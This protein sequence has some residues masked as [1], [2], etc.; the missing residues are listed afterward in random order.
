MVIIV[1]PP[2][3][4]TTLLRSVLGGRPGVYTIAESMTDNGRL[5]LTHNTFKDSLDLAASGKTSLYKLNTPAFVDFEAA[6]ND[7]IILLLRDGRDACA[8]YWNLDSDYRSRHVFDDIVKYWNEIVT[9]MLSMRDL[10]PNV[11]LFKYE[12]LVVDPYTVVEQICTFCG[13]P[14]N[15]SMIDNYTSAETVPLPEGQTSWHPRLNSPITADSVGRYKTD[16]NQQ[17]KDSFSIAT[18]VMSALGY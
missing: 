4:G 2:R 15:D 18:A 8:S 5:R 1:G 6:K 12:D 9:Y 14:Y 7:K 10:Y 16:L 11:R 3:S 13:I 17:Q